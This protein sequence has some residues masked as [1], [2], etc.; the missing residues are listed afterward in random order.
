M[1]PPGPDTTRAPKVL[2]PNGILS[3]LA[4]SLCA[5]RTYT[6]H[7]RL[8]RLTLDDY[9]II[10]AEIFS[11]TGYVL[12]VVASAYGW[13]HYSY[14]VPQ[15]RKTLALKLILVTEV[16]WNVTIS[17][18]RISIAVW[19]LRLSR[20]RSWRIALFSIIVLQTLIGIGY[21]VIIFG[22][23][24][25][26]S[27]NWETVPNLVCWPWKVGAVWGW[28]TSGFMIVFDLMLAIMP[29]KLVRTLSRPLCERILI[30][31]LMATG[32]IATA[33]ACVKLNTYHRNPHKWAVPDP[34][35]DMVNP[36]VYSKMEELLGIIAA[37]MPCLK[38]PAEEILRRIG[39]LSE[40]HWP[41]LSKNSFVF[42]TMAR[43][44]VGTEAADG[45]LP[46]QDVG[47]LS[48]EE[49]QGS[50]LGLA[51]V[52]TRSTDW[53]GTTMQTSTVESRNSMAEE[54]I[55]MPPHSLRVEEV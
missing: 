11:L 6:H 13:G 25:P 38:R 26:L 14:Y 21:I 7:R 16:Q 4:L 48:H 20:A 29:I 50:E 3:L 53:V 46:L 40:V 45:P 36:T 9:L 32:L 19:L 43:G 2:I 52:R 8:S 44:S 41:G 42:S 39:L 10:A 15:A 31:F 55:K 17:L 24:R 37:C 51:S 35:V 27:Y 30:S 54:V 34:L 18:I 22:T 12:L 23:C 1:E 47:K 33:V 49:S 5:A 28:T